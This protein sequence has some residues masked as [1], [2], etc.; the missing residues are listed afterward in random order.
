[1]SQLNVHVIDQ[2]GAPVAG[3][4]VAINTFEAD[5]WGKPGIPI[6]PNPRRTGGDGSVNF[7]NGPTL[8]K[9]VMV[10]ATCMDGTSDPIPFDGT[11]DVT[12]TVTAIP[13]E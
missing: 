1:M 11:T 2:S 12:V 8:T 5:D 6:N 13:F 9:A 7:Y 10:Q 3:R 4:L